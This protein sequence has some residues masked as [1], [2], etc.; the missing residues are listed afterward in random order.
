MAPCAPR[1]PPMKESGVLTLASIWLDLGEGV[2]NRSGEGAGMYLW[3]LMNREELR[4]ALEANDVRP[5]SYSLDSAVADDA[6]CM[7][8]SRGGWSVYFFERGNRNDERW[9]A[10]EAEVCQHFLERVVGDPTTRRHRR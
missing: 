10:T 1:M 6:Y 5:S 7:E 9:F 4:A 8:Q 2:L 3:K